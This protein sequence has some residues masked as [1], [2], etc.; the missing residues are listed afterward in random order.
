MNGVQIDQVGRR[1]KSVVYD[2]VAKVREALYTWGLRPWTEYAFGYEA[3]TDWP[4]RELC[5]QSCVVGRSSVLM[6]SWQTED[7]ASGRPSDSLL[8]GL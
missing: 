3:N 6:C 4:V 8:D 2:T 5:G 1:R 7:D